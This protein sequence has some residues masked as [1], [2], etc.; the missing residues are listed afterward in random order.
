MGAMRLAGAT[1]KAVW[2]RPWHALSPS[3][4]SE[5]RHTGD[6]KGYEVPV[7]VYVFEAVAHS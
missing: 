5:E 2:S 6:S 3:C 4:H 7:L 1:P